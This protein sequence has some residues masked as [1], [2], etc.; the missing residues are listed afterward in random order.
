MVM[1]MTDLGWESA[2]TF[3]VGLDFGLFK[4][5]ITGNIDWYRKNTFDLLL[6]RSI[7]AIHGLTDETAKSGWTHPAV[8]QNIGKTRNTGFEVS[9]NSRNIVTGKFNWITNGNF[10]FNKNEIVSLYGIIDPATG[11]E[12]DDISNKW[13]IGQPIRVNYGVVWGGVWQL[14]E[15]EAAAVYGSQPGYVKLKDINGDGKLDDKDRQIQGQLDPKI[16]WGITNTITYGNFSF[17]FFFHGVNG[18]TA[19]NDRMTDDVQSDLRYNT[20]KK[21]WWTPEN[22]TNDWYMNAKMA[23]EMSGFG[24][25][26]YEST[27]FIRLKDVSLAY[28]LP[29]NA[30]SRIGLS[31]VKVYVSGRNLLTITKWSGLDPE[32]VDQAAQRNVP[33]QKE[34]I[35]GLSFGF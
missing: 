26:L 5:R 27:D 12:I 24:S 35:F 15:E 25:T 29:K 16:L 14:G 19:H 9:I 18:I 20:V 4:D 22:P 11:K 2:K 34:L 6:E 33:M 10:S 30:I 3:N 8:T 28:E 17:S 31:N 1:G 13:F 23:N 32:L 7:S 21:N